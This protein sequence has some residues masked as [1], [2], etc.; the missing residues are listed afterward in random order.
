MVTQKEI[1]YQ[2]LINERDR[3]E[4]DVA[5]LRQTLR[6]REPDAVDCLE[7]ALAKERLSC[8][9]DYTNHAIAIFKM[10]CPADFEANLVKIDFTSYKKAA[11]ELR[12]FKKER[13]KK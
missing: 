10:S 2:Y 6:M 1:F 4:E 8:F 9:L 3:L 12:K 13:V 11:I 5:R 7:L